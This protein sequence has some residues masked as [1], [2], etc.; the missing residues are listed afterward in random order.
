MAS[1]VNF[2]AKFEADHSGRWKFCSDKSMHDIEPHFRWRE[3]YTAEADPR[4]PFFGRTYSEFEFTHRLYNYYLHPQWDSF[5]SA[6][7]YAK[8]L[9]ADYEE[10]YVLIELIGEWNDTLHNDIMLLKR[11]LIDPLMVEGIYKFAFFCRQFAQLPRFFRR[12]LL[13]RVGRRNRGRRRV[14]HVA[15]YPPPSRRR[16]EKR[17]A[18]VLPAFWRR[19]QRH[20]LEGSKTQLAF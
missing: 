8:I 11:N 9:F 3:L 10:G 17:N 5:G 1:G 12:R 6:T 14:G 18:G 4:S 2:A 19:I 16:I 20:P 15:Q 7:L 13:C